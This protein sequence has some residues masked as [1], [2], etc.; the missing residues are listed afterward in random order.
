MVVGAIATQSGEQTDRHVGG[1]FQSPTVRQRPGIQETKAITDKQ[2]NKKLERWLTYKST[3]KV[4]AGSQSVVHYALAMYNSDIHPCR[5]QK[6]CTWGP[7]MLTRDRWGH[8]DPP[9]EN[10]D[11]LLPS[12]RSHVRRRVQVCHQMVMDCHQRTLQ[13]INPH[14]HFVVHN[15]HQQQ[16]LLW[17]KAIRQTQFG[18]H[19]TVQV[20]DSA[21]SPAPLTESA[22]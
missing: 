3:S 10:L 12:H 8:C 2:A 6:K 19:R 14:M 7:S 4:A 9:V 11:F 21:C 16:H 13:V 17:L 1:S 5:S 15:F 18:S 20:L 22:L